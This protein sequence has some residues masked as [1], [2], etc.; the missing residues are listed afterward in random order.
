[1]ANLKEIKVRISAVKKTKQITS[2]M[3]LVA[4]AKLKRATD[5]ALAARPYREQLAGVLA[6]VAAVAG[7]DV[8][9]PLLK[10]RAEVRSILVVVLTSD[11]GL[12]GPF[13]N[14]LL[15]KSYEWLG[16]KKTKTAITLLPYGRK[17]ADGLKRVTD[18]ERLPAV[19]E[20]AKQDK[21]ELVRNLSSQMVTGFVDGQYDEVYIVYNRFVNTLV[22]VPTFDRVLPLSIDQAQSAASANSSVDYRY[23]PGGPEILGALLP[24]YL[25]T[26]IL[27]SFLETEAGEHAARMTAMDN[28]KKNA[29]EL[30]DRLTLDYNR[31]RQA[32]ITT[33][34]IEIV[35]GAQAL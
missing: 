15:R 21:L 33:E 35:A 3:K 28:A 11:R 2:A 4:A 18:V 32:A 7:D 16:E 24:L 5:R 1:M 34:I 23:E 25:R 30:I 13:N 26:L 9:E 8:D 6:R 14:G 27:Q 31:A 29:S 12:C 22:Q 20:Y 19:L 10:T 17:G